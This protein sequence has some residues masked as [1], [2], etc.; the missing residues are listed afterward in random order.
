MINHSQ[1]CLAKLK[2][3]C[4]LMLVTYDVFVAM[5]LWKNRNLK[6]QKSIL[7]VPTQLF[8]T[9][10]KNMKHGKSYCLSEYIYF[11]YGN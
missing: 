6:R 2:G 5:D 4:K 9:W 8:G 3:W 1:P 11:I 7:E 10:R